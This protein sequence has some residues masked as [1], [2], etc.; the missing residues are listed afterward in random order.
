M[1]SRLRIASLQIPSLKILSTSLPLFFIAGM[2]NAANAPLYQMTTT[3]LDT[4]RGGS[5]SA[6]YPTLTPAAGKNWKKIN[7]AIEREIKK[8]GCEP[9]SARSPIKNEVTITTKMGTVNEK[10]MSMT[11]TDDVT[12]ARAAHPDTVIFAFTYDLR[13]GKP[14][15][16][17][18][19]FGVTNT[20]VFPAEPI[21][22]SPEAKAA[23]ENGVALY[24]AADAAAR[25]ERVVVLKRAMAQDR[26]AEENLFCLSMDEN[27][28]AATMIERVAEDEFS[29]ALLGKN[30]IVNTRPSGAARGCTFEMDI[31]A[32]SLADLLPKKSVVR[33]WI[34]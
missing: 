5:F 16:L 24:D 13:T 33:D 30:A 2:A 9:T 34:R 15:S 27:D 18:G 23:F 4:P 20:A 17:E 1:K 26:I 21:D 31:P 12:C 6:E 14:V 8:L 11:I 19:E 25:A 22:D 7:R 29:I 28:T 10:F 3:A 32:T